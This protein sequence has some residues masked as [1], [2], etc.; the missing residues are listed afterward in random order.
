MKRL[1]ML[2]LIAGALT[3]CSGRTVVVTRAP[4]PPPRPVAVVAR[5][6]APGPGYVWVDGYHD[7]RANRYVWVP[8]TWM[9]PPRVRAVWVP[10]HFA[11]RGRGQVWVA[12]HWR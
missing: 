3:A 6:V 9:R 12:G 11:P 7:W 4:L 1:M 2:T 8:G 5:G 10:G